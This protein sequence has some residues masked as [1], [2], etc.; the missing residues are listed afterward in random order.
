MPHRPDDAHLRRGDEEES[1]RGHRDWAA[2]SCPGDNL[3]PLIEGGD[4]E[5][6]VRERI[7][8]G[9][10]A[11]DVVCGSDGADLVVAIEDGTA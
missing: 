1:I 11:L 4:V 2:T 5:R 6:A 10:V 7:A 9:G 3:Y 8:A